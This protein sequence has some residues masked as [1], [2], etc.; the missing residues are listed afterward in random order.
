MRSRLWATP[1]ALVP[2]LRDGMPAAA[3]GIHVI[4]GVRLRFAEARNPSQREIVGDM[5]RWQ[6]RFWG[7]LG[8]MA[9]G[10][11][12]SSAIAATGSSFQLFLFITTSA[13][14]Y[15]VLSGLLSQIGSKK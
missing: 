9:A 5:Q 6:I 11:A 15:L 2:S 13:G 12:F 10:Y 1:T 14:L 7:A 4:L 8:A 3:A